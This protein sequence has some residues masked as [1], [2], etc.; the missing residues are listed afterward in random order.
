MPQ[1]FI[2][3]KEIIIGIKEFNMNHV[4]INFVIFLHYKYTL[5]NNNCKTVNICQ[6]NWGLWHF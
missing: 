1:T 6:R 5:T 3:P 2:F 4:T